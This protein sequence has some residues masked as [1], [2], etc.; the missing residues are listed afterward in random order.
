[1]YKKISKKIQYYRNIKGVS[2]EK[3]SIDTGL[4]MN[5]LK[6]IEKCTRKPSLRTI[7]KIC[8]ALDINYKDLF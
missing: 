6:S 4:N 8:K 5:F 2:L 7:E 1:M 3:L